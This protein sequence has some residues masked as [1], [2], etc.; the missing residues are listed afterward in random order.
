MNTP[1]LFIMGVVVTLIVGFALGLVLYGAILDG[2]EQRRRER[3]L[4]ASRAPGARQPVT[5]REV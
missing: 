3:A 4:E 5:G 2:R 1:G